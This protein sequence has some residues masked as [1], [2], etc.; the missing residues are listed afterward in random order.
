MEADDN[1]ITQLQTFSD[2]MVLALKSKISTEIAFK[3]PK[4]KNPTSQRLLANAS[5][6]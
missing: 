4:S 2:E 1:S 6:I 3:G 5:K